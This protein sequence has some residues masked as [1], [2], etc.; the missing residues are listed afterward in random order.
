[1]LK[2]LSEYYKKLSE[3]FKN[4]RLLAPYIWRTKYLGQ[5]T[6]SCNQNDVVFVKNIKK[7]GLVCKVKQTQLQIRYMDT[8]GKPR[9]QWFKKSDITHLLGGSTFIT[10]PS[11]PEHEITESLTNK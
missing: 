3:G 4:D 11:I 5:V 10:N 7:L 9:R 2:Q 6:R 8:S 1:M